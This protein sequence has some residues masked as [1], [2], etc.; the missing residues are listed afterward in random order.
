[1]PL[2]NSPDTNMASEYNFTFRLSGLCL[3]CYVVLLYAWLKLGS[4]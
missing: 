3:L 4:L 2:E 1:M